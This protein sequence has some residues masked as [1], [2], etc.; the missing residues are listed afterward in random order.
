MSFATEQN[1]TDYTRVIFDTLMGI[2]VPDQL[3]IFNDAQKMVRIGT[4][5]DVF[6]FIKSK[7]WHRSECG[8]FTCPHSESLYDHLLECG[9]L[10]YEHAMMSNL[11]R[12]TCVKAYIAGL[13]HD[14]GKIGTVRQT[15]KHLTF[16]GH[17]LVGGAIL[18]N[19]WSEEID[20][21]LR[22][23]LEDWG[24]IS[25]CADVHMCSYFGN[26]TTQLHKY[27]ANILPHGVK[28]LLAC[29]RI[30]DHLSMVPTDD[31]PKSAEEIRDV[32]LST[33]ADYEKWLFG[34]ITIESV[35]KNQGVLI[36]LQGTSA[37]G[38]STFARNLEF[39]FGDACVVINRDFF[40]IRQT[41]KFVGDEPIK[42]IEEMTP[43]V[44]SKY[45]AI[46]QANK[47]SISDHVNSGMS[48]AIHEGLQ[49]GKIVVVDTMA[50]MFGE[51]QAILPDI[52][53]DAYRI[54]F[55]FHRN[56]FITEE[57]SIGRLGLSLETQLSIRGNQLVWNP[58]N[59]KINWFN[60]VSCTESDLSDEK[61]LWTQ[62][63]LSI[64][65]GWNHTK[66]HILDHLFYKIGEMY[67]YNQS[68]PR[69]PI[70][71][72]TM[73]MTLLELIQRLNTIGGLDAI[74]Q[75]FLPYAYTVNRQIPGVIGIKYKDGINQIWQPKWA[76][77]ARG[78]FYWIGMSQDTVVIELKSALQRGAEI[79]TSA[80]TVSATQDVD[81]KSWD[82][83]DDVQR[84]M[85]KAFSTSSGISAFLTSKVDGSLFVVNVYPKSCVQ[86]PIMCEL[87]LTHGDA[88]TQTLARHC[89]DEGYSYLVTISTQGTLFIGDDMQDYFLTAIQSLIARPIETLDDWSW[90]KQDFAELILD[91]YY[92]LE[93][94]NAEMVNFCFE[95]YC[96]DRMTIA[97]RLH[98][99]LAVGY[100]HS[101]FNLLGMMNKGKYV[102]HFDMPR[103][104][105]KQPLYCSIRRTDD[106]FC[107]MG[108]LDEV[109][110]GVRSLEDF[111]AENFVI[112]EF[113]SRVIHAEGFVLLTPLVAGPYDYAKV[114]T[115]LYYQCHKVKQTKVKELLSL[116]LSCS[117]HYPILSKLHDF[118]DKMGDNFTKLIAD[119]YSAVMQQVDPCSAMYQKQTAKARTHWD[120]LHSS[121]SSGV[122]DSKLATPVCKMM[123]NTKES[124]KELTEMFGPITQELYQLQSTEIILF[125]KD[126]LMKVEPWKDDW[127]SRLKHL[128]ETFDDTVNQLYGIVIGFSD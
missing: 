44:Y 60:N 79:L 118:F 51:I 61:K 55:W 10:C 111:I 25:T 82:K 59:E 29:L 77:E 15:G 54:S 45:C 112:D 69:I 116:P 86:Y 39:R 13:L 23:T 93:L 14:I 96:K 110:L 7:H 123:L 11:D 47:K 33:Q 52:A 67:V 57:E 48:R 122:V 117:L 121:I 50:T 88:F 22:L 65:L 46:Y 83:F 125:V 109:V 73:D 127:E 34:V 64:S 107:M 42:T 27:S 30:G 12:K 66:G 95:G 115:N 100:D 62:P 113:T 87:A 18:E 76:R 6:D 24:D 49:C 63:H 92:S 40:M 108:K 28:E 35:K 8:N 19:M 53:K 103:M 32:V 56:T 105:F 26:Q 17:G 85:L 37:S 58:F 80:H 128:F 98:T 70:L 21:M 36:L 75:F 74:T 2:C 31:Y 94:D 120:K 81:P 101:G 119:S 68:I 89:I 126:L 99:E 91:Y 71:D 3:H 72:Q 106:V 104:T 90:A 4:W 84:A 97:G 5:R 78:R 43:T 114:K 41:M 102:P 124:I 9:R 38:K 20:V 16:K 1:T